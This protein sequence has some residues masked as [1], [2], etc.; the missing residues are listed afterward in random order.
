MWTSS[1]KI[2]AQTHRSKANERWIYPRYV[3]PRKVDEVF[4]R[5]CLIRAYEN[6]RDIS[7]VKR[8]FRK[9]RKTVKDIYE[10]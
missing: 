1:F 2:F 3:E 4:A 9:V 10:R 7:K 5:R 6:L 8:L